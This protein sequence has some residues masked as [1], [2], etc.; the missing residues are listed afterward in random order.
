MFE[1]LCDD[2]EQYNCRVHL[3]VIE[4]YNTKR[5]TGPRYAVEVMR[6]ASKSHPKARM[7]Y[8]EQHRRDSPGLDSMA[9]TLLIDLEQRGVFGEPPIGA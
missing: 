2:A 9:K 1:Q 6:Q 3:I 5:K 7:A 4:H 8:A